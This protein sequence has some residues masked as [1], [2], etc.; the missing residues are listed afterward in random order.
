MI[1]ACYARD[2]GYGYG[3]EMWLWVSG[4]YV[5][6]CL[7]CA[8]VKVNVVTTLQI[9]PK[10]NRIEPKLNRN[11]NRFDLNQSRNR[12]KPTEN[13][14]AL[15]SMPARTQPQENRNEPKLNQTQKF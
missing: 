1:T 6:V 5:T 14:T 9:E 4:R 12:W 15:K 7:H 2:Y 13:E 8:G 3:Y 10:W 11:R